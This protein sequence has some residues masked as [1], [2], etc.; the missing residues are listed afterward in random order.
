MPMADQSTS[1]PRKKLYIET[2]GCQMNV[3]DS[4]LVVARLRE[5]GYELTTEIDQAD[6]IL[7][8]T[9]SVRQHAEDKIYSALGRIKHIKRRRPEVSIGVLGCMAQ[10]DQEQ[11]LKRAPH[12][13]VVVGP[14]QLARVPQLLSRAREVGSPQLAVSLDRDAGSRATIT[15]SFEGYDADR[16][17]SMRPSPFQAYVRVMIGCDKFCTYCIVPSV[18][19]PEQ[20]RHPEQI[21]LETRQLADEGCKE[22]TLLGQTVNSYSYDLGDGRTARLSDLLARIHDTTGIERIK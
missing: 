17:P 16:E 19:G 3:L 18:R 22:I 1:Q 2:V 5:Q 8:N 14:G 4:E 7:Y 11:I 10:K 12:V 15:A 21:A 20:S 9:C 6:T 13:D